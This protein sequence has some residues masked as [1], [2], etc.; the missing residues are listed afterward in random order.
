MSGPT[1]KKAKGLITSD[2]FPVR[3]GGEGEIFKTRLTPQPA[4]T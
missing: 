3:G 2:L 4:E 1:K